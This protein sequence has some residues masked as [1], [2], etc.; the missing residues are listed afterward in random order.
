MR[1]IKIM[2]GGILALA[3]FAGTATA[4]PVKIRVA[5]TVAVANWAS[6]LLEKKDLA[7]HLG[8][9]YVFEPVHYAGTPLMITAMA[10]G[11]LEIGD[12]AYS[13]LALAIENAGMDD[14]KVI[15]DDFQDGVGGNYSNEY[16]VLQD[17]P[18]KK[19]EDLKGQ[20][21]ATNAAG[22][23]V[24]IAMRAM[25]RQHGLEDKRDY[26]M[27]EATFPTM[28]AMLTGK[29]AALIP[30]VIPFSLNPDF[31]NTARV[32]FT[33][34]AAIGPT[35][36]IVFTARKSFIDKN[37][38]ALVDMMEDMVRIV[39]W[40]LDPANH[41]E[42]V[43]IAARLTKQPPERFDPWLFTAKDYYRD[44]D[45]KPN[46]TSLQANIATQKQLGFIK[47][48]IDVKKYADL[49]IIEEAAKRLKQ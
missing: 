9:S 21:I 35:Q 31:R 5:W 14:M 11:D 34:K 33:Q 1:S 4:E 39:R 48:E 10:T 17:S 49:S 22:S 7:Q 37:R 26:T 43:A 44:P 41:K 24:D 45:L 16:F 40:Y 29:K 23:A 36:M 3:L 27:V 46:L 2:P 28:A 20:V 38:A 32:L 25:L 13:T 15:G 47:S 8:K 18:I 6:L 30:G 19:V 42:A 12:L